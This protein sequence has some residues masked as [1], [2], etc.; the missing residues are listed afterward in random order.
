MNYKF[1]ETELLNM[2]FRIMKSHI[3][4]TVYHRSEVTY[5]PRLCVKSLPLSPC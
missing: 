3:L 1:V 5:C 4:V 2:V